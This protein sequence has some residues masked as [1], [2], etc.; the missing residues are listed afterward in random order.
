MFMSTLK[1]LCANKTYSQNCIIYN[2]FI[3]FIYECY[4]SGAEKQNKKK[5]KKSQYKKKNKI[6][7]LVYM[8][9]LLLVKSFVKLYY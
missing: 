3:I 9:S 7:S 2:S 4:L 6:T 5:N 8:I 1:V